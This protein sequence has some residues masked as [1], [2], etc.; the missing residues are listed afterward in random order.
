[1]YTT[2]PETFF[3]V[4]IDKDDNNDNT[5]VNAIVTTLKEKHKKK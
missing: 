4:A 5:D 2:Y 3:R 1:M